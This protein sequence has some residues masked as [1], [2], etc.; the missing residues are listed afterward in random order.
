MSDKFKMSDI[1]TDKKK[2]RIMA[3]IQF[4]YR[5][6]SETAPITLRLSHGRGIDLSVTMRGVMSKREFWYKDSYKGGKKITKHREFSELSYLGGEAK[7]H[8][9]ALENIKAYVYSRLVEDYNAGE[10]ITRE[11]LKKVIDEVTQ[12]VDNRNKIHEIQ[13][14][15]EE[16]KNKNLVLTALVWYRN[17]ER[18]NKSDFVRFDY[19]CKL[20]EEYNAGL[21][22]E[23]L[24]QSFINE[25]HEHITEVL[26]YSTSTAKGLV[27][28]LLRACKRYYESV[29]GVEISR[30]LYS[31]KTPIKPQQR[32]V[33]TLS[34]E[35][36]EQIDKTEVP[37]KLL[38]AKR[39]IL[40]HSETGARVSD[41]DKLI[42][43]NLITE[44]AY[45][46]WKFYT[47][48]TNHLSFVPLTDKIRYY[49]DKYGMYQ[50]ENI[51]CL[52]QKIPLVCKMAGITQEIEG[53][54]TQSVTINGKRTQRKVRGVY[55]KYK[56]ISTHTLRRSFA[57][58]YY[59]K[60]PNEA[61]R[62]VT[63]HTSDKMLMCYINRERAYNVAEMV[64][65][66]NQAR[67]DE[68]PPLMKIAR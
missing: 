22:F 48:K 53:A 68:K 2:V 56:L 16:R 38:N 46:Y 14:Q 34:F 28:Y 63:G 24:N 1:Y 27:R 51:E 39:A 30:N 59:Q 36:L 32:N 45:S 8:K 3:K 41:W 11:W 58:N 47:Q 40:I 44:G 12:G 17:E 66:F 6:K 26:K 55:Q 35:E 31:L 60:M 49:I 20:L 33:I 62:D 4:K 15:K 50:R 5:S 54:K 65:K 67:K 19:T 18:K 57:T 42:D 25:F 13:Q 52:R 61:I 29:E 43:E 37:K 10:L 21:T 23:E 7:A 64:S 9:K